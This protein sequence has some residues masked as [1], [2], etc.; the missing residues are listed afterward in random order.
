MSWYFYIPIIWIGLA[1][2][3]AINFAVRY[4]RAQLNLTVRAA[5]QCFI[6]SLWWP[7]YLIVYGLD[8]VWREI[9]R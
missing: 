7:L 9:N 5:I 3:L 4:R 2:P 8:G 6:D 1:I